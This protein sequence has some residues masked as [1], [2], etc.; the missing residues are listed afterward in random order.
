MMMRMGDAGELAMFLAIGSV[1][2][3]VLVG[4]IG[5]AIGRRISRGKGGDPATGLTT[6][7]MAAERLS[8]LE[9]RIAELES[10]RGQL[11]RLEFA[12]RLLTRGDDARAPG[13]KADG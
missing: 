3:T 9:D 2:V 12:E 10:E 13:L 1:L 11:E 4:P 8:A 6:G 7:E 5:Q